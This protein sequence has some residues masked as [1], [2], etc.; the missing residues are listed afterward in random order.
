VYILLPTMSCASWFGEGNSACAASKCNLV[1]SLA[2]RAFE[3]ALSLDDFEFW[4][5]S[6]KMSPHELASYKQQAVDTK[7]Q[8]RCS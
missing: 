7:N 4:K 2:S 5:A 1:Q 6:L 8:S 3:L